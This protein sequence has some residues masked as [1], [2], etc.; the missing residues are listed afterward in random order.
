MGT[1]TKENFSEKNVP[2]DKIGQQL[3]S[4]ISII[5]D[6]KEIFNR[7]TKKSRGSCIYFFR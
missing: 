3:H 2:N 6:N 7:K 5:H 4:Y 1:R